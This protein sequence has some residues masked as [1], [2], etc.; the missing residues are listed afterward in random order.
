M[1]K[2]IH[3]QLKIGRVD[4]SE[5]QLDLQ[6][7]DEIPKILYPLFSPFLYRMLTLFL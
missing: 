2:V 3:R 1:R 6:S 7:R 4:I 5:I